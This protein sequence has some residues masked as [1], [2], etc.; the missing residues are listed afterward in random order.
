MLKIELIFIKYNLKVDAKN[1][2]DN[3]K[4]Q[5]AKILMLKN[6]YHNKQNHLFYFFRVVTIKKVELKTIQ[7]LEELINKYSFWTEFVQIL[8][9][10][11]HIY[12]FSTLIII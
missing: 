6:Y 9:F 4:P 8:K 7:N 2:L 3:L 1:S 12:C 5:K 11:K 10:N